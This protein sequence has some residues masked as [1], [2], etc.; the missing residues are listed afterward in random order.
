MKPKTPPT[1]INA[2]DM[3]NKINNALKTAKIDNLLVST[4]AISQS[5]TSIVFTTSEGTAE[6]LL[7]HQ[8]VWNSLFEFTDIRKDEKWYKLIVHGIPT[9]IFD[10]ET[11][12]KLV[13]DEVETFNKDIKLAMLPHWLTSK[14]ARQGKQ[15]G[16]IVLTVKT[17]QELQKALRNRLVIAGSSVRTAIY[18]TCKP[19]D[20]CRKCQKFEHLQTMCKNENKC[21]ICAGN[22][23]TR[24]HGC[25]LC[26][27][28]KGTTCGHTIYKCSNCDEKHSANS[29]DC[30]VFRALQP[31]S[32]TADPLA[33]EQS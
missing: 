6:D 24:E 33:M 4:V 17:E 22:H 31:I 11:G 13:K 27:Q 7:K 12:M 20:Q 10:S 28:L 16:S 19:T 21:Q 23:N 2:I 15:H 32:S 5:K 30:S 18:T 29:L 14:E 25:F 9:A 3:R 26:P 8:H 1:S